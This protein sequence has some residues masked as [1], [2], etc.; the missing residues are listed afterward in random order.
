MGFKSGIKLF[1][2]LDSGLNLEHCFEPNTPNNFHIFVLKQFQ[3]CFG[4]MLGVIV[5]LEHQSSPQSKVVCTLKQVLIKDLPV[6]GSIHCSL[7]P[8]H[9]YDAATPMLHGRDGVRR[10]MSCTWFSP[11]IELCIQ[12]KE[13]HFCLIRPKNILPYVLRVFHKPFCKLQVCCRVPFLSKPRLG[14]R[15]RVCCP[16]GRCSHL[17]QGTL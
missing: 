12:A 5:L 17:S 4:F 14:K 1:H 16:S 2:L 11:D 7:Y 3:H 15:G 10:V 13:L 9:P 8:Y 6:F